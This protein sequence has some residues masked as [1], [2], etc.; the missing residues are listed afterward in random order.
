VFFNSGYYTEHDL[1][2]AGFKSLG[3]D[4]R[5]D[6]TC[7]II[8]LKN[9]SIGSNVRIDGYTTISAGSGTL[10]IGSHIHISGYS[11]FSC[12]AGI[13]MED[14]S[15]MSH[16]SKL[17]TASDDYVGPFMTNAVVPDKFKNVKTGPIVLKRHSLIG[18]GVVVLPN[19]TIGTG[20][21]VGAMSL[22]SRS[23]DDWSVYA[24]IPAKKIRD[25]P[26][27]LLELERKYLEELGG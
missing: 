9:I 12:A 15:A 10:E 27:D 7:T 22:V 23:T 25:R 1:K 5:I 17:Y 18:S 13:V 24:G 2:D 11:L 6:K 20:T 26:K 14:F 19:V 21:T 4:V 8:G 16:G 3:T